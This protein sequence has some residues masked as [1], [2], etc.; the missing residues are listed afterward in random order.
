MVEE[1]ASTAIIGFPV[2]KYVAH[3]L[4]LCNLHPNSFNS[5]TPRLRSN[6]VAVQMR[7]VHPQIK[8]S[9]KVQA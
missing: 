2:R 6:E 4:Y 5:V 1:A 9:E 3:L 8:E 7:T